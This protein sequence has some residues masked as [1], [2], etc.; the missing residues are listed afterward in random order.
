[1]SLAHCLELFW[2]RIYEAFILGSYWLWLRQCSSRYQRGGGTWQGSKWR[3]GVSRVWSGFGGCERPRRTGVRRQDK[4]HSLVT[5][6]RDDWR[7]IRIARRSGRTA[8]P[9]ARLGCATWS[10]NKKIS[11]EQHGGGSRTPIRRS[12]RRLQHTGLKF[13]LLSKSVVLCCAPLPINKKEVPGEFYI[14]SLNS[15]QL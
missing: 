1:M 7:R 3:G 11:R 6:F 12:L 10:S 8:R 2:V 13:R 15:S 5:S 9:L 4:R 14:F